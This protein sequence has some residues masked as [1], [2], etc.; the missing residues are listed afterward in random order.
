VTTSTY[1]GANEYRQGHYPIDKSNIYYNEIISR[2]TSD[3]VITSTPVT[4]LV[5]YNSDWDF[6]SNAR[7]NIHYMIYCDDS[8]ISSYKP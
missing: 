5:K 2:V 4:A 3:E 6:D 8:V 7:L 1:H